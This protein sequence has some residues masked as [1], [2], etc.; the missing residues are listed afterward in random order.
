MWEFP[1]RLSG[2]GESVGVARRR[3]RYLLNSF[4]IAEN[5][6][7]LAQAQQ[8]SNNFSDC[9]FAI[10]ERDLVNL[11]LQPHTKP[12]QFGNPR[13]VTVG[14]YHVTIALIFTAAK[15]EQNNAATKIYQ[16]ASHQLY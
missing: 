7:R 1:R 8:S 15:S 2:V 10:L 9:V 3:H 11:Q 5:T 13:P 16:S 14:N 6:D 12:F 4:I